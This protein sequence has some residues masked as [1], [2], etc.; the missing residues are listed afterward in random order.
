MS[1]TEQATYTH[2]HH[3]SV[4]RDHARRTAADSAAFLIP[5]LKPTDHIL[6]LGCGPGTITTDL[7]E[8]VP[9][10]SVVGVDAAEAVLGQA[11]ALADSRGLKN[12]EFKPMDG[13]SL[14]FA[15]AQFDVVYCHQVLQ[16]VKDPVSILREMQ[17][18]AR[19]GGLV[20][21]READFK[22][23]VWYPQPPEL[24]KWMSVYQLAARANGGE[25]YAGRYVHVW[26]MAAGF[27]LEEINTSWSTW[28]HSGERAAAFA[29]SW[30]GRTL[31]SGTAETAKREGIAGEEQLQQIS[32]AWK[33]WGRETGAFIAIPHGE[34]LCRKPPL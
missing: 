22:G 28:H 5:H 10:G 14:A 8:L 16:H 34:I 2:G 18:V 27:K 25:P 15:D 13:N 21:A 1:K 6:D 3:S 12:V 7:A 23:F 20:A 29:D 31:F 4:V 19:P 32:D 17:R 24:D 9:Q 30:A 11:R 33:K 26:A